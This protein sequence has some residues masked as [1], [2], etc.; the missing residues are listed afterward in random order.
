[1]QKE[2]FLKFRSQ[3]KAPIPGQSLTNDPESPAPYE[4]AP[5][6]TSVHDASLYLWSEIT[7]PEM[8]IPVMESLSNKIFNLWCGINA[9]NNVSS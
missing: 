2:E 3:M 8:Y 4:Q 1:M 6:F 9:R 5:R 7:D